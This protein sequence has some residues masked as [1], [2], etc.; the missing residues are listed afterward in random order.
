MYKHNTILSSNKMDK[1]GGI[2]LSDITINNNLSVIKTIDASN[3]DVS[4]LTVKTLLKASQI[5]FT[6]IQM[7]SV[8]VPTG[9]LYQDMS[10]YIKIKL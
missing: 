5:D 1:T 7:E 8:E 2:F 10:G 3:I 4:G 6:G 9:Y